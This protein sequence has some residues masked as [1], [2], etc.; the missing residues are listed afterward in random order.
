[1]KNCEINCCRCSERDTCAD[2]N[3]H[4]LDKLFTRYGQPQKVWL[5]QE[6][7]YIKHFKEVAPCV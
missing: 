3:K 5:L 6:R 2:K 1:M 7:K 4:L